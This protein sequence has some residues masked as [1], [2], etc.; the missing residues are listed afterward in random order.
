MDDLPAKA[1]ELFVR[2]SAVLPLVEIAALRQAV[3]DHLAS[4]RI[5]ARKNELLPLDLA[6]ELA[7]KLDALLR[8]IAAMP[9]PQ[10][11]LAVGAA[12]YF[13][14]LD[15]AQPDTGGVLGLDDDVA[16]FNY[17]VR[18]MGRA[19]LVIEP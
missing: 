4:I 5:A 1:I 15:D 6:E 11:R 13:V 7:D 12:R 19:D 14:S 10:H 16:V 3:R 8:D 2:S 18:Q 9:D 17:A